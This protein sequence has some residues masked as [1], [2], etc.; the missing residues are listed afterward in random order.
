VPQV[1]D[2]A[3]ALKNSGSMRSRKLRKVAQMAATRV[4]LTGVAEGGAKGGGLEGTWGEGRGLGRHMGWGRAVF[5]DPDLHAWQPS[6]WP[7]ESQSRLS[8][9]HAPLRPPPGTPLQ[10][11]L[12][13]LHALLAFLLP[14][15]FTSGEGANALA[16]QARGVAGGG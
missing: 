2:E 3:H 12:Q 6:P 13:E 16:E 1:M 10:N 5:L 15:I 9:L 7:P 14:G 8:P 4:M 11:D